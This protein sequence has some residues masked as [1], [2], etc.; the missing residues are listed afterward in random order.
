MWKRLGAACLGFNL[1]MGTPSQ[2]HM[3]PAEANHP[4][5]QYLDDENRQDLAEGVARYCAGLDMPI[6]VCVNRLGKDL[7]AA[8]AAAQCAGEVG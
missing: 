2:A 6:D 4:A 8:E 5:L 3:V 1:V 7:R